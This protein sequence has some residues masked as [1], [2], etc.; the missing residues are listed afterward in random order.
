VIG[1]D[2]ISDLSTEFM[3]FELF[4]TVNYVTELTNGIG[5]TGLEKKSC[6]RIN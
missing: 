3:K 4:F 2:D 6:I 1:L 5:L